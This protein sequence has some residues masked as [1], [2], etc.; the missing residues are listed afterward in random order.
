MKQKLDEE[1]INQEFEKLLEEEFNAKINQDLK[2]EEIIQMFK[3]NVSIQIISQ[4]TRTPIKQVIAYYQDY[5][6]SSSK[7][8]SFVK[9]H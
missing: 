6:N 1:L 9:K 5:I 7:N 2:K 3:Q 8:K 4:N